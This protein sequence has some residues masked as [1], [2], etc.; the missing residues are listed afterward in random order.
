MHTIRSAI[1]SGTDIRVDQKF[2]CDDDSSHLFVNDVHKYKID[3]HGCMTDVITTKIMGQ[4]N[5]ATMSMDVW[6]YTKA[7]EDEPCHFGTFTDAE[8]LLREELSV[9]VK[10][11]AGAI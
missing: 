9:G 2:D 5:L 8:N 4:F 6:N 10:Y 3:C 7:D 1:V 11:V